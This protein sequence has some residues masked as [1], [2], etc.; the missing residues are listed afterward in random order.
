MEKTSEII[1]DK[2][3]Y[4]C[5]FETYRGHEEFIPNHFLGFQ[6]SGE[7]HAFHEQGTTIIKENTVVLVR[8]NQLI[9]T[10]KHP[11]KGEKYQFISITLDDETLRQYAAEQKMAMEV[12]FPNHQRLFFEPDDFFKSYFASLIPYV[13]KTKEISQRLAVLKVKEAL[14]LLLQSNPNLKNLLFD[15]T[16]PHKIDL[17]EFMNKNFMFN[18]S[19]EAFAQLTG[20]SLSGFKR[21]FSKIFGMA[22]KQ[23]LKEKRLKEA[24]HLIKDKNKKPS[25]IY[26]DLGFENL[27]H[28]YFSFKKKYG[29]TT[30]ELQPN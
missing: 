25:D 10:V 30:T 24:Y 28:F 19:V 18:V 7:T 5:A 1:F 3:V 4:S 12:P 16:E 2:L 13:N 22:P 27:S 15:F 8:K 26:L 20:R 17:K 14:E 29:V 21:D 6:I 11:S 23:W 9:R